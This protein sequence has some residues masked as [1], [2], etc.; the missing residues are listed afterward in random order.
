MRITLT[1]VVRYITDPYNPL[2]D[3]NH[4]SQRTQKGGRGKTG[5]LRIYEYINYS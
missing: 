3:I 1:M 4:Y 2:Y 5:S